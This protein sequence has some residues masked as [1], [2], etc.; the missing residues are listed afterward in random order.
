MAIAMYQYGSD[1]HFE[2][3]IGFGEKGNGFAVKGFLFPFPLYPFPFNRTVLRYVLVKQHFLP[4]NWY[5]INYRRNY[6][7]HL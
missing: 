7:I 6:R 1:K 3:K 2:L 5:L 4:W